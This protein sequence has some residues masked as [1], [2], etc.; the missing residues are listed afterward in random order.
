MMR[1]ENE[2][3]RTDARELLDRARS[4][5]RE[6]EDKIRLMR[7]QTGAYSRSD[8]R[9]SILSAVGRIESSQDATPQL[10]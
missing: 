8:T 1:L 4:L 6:S 2:D 9:G 7:A 5:P 10:H 3:E